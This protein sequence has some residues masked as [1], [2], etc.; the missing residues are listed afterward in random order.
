MNRV[1]QLDQQE[2]EINT[3]IQELKKQ[4]KA[5]RITERLKGTGVEDPTDRIEDCVE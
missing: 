2:E 1:Q 3:A 5:M 4:E